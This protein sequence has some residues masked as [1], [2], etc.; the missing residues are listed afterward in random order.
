MRSHIEIR[1]R[2]TRRGPS[3][4]LD[5]VALAALS[6]A[7][8]LWQQPVFKGGVDLIVVDAQVVD[9]RGQPMLDLDDA[10]FEVR[11]NTKR[12]RIISAQLVHQAPSTRT[13]IPAGAGGVA[14]QQVSTV[15]RAF[16]LAVDESSFQPQHALAAMKAARRFVDQIP[17]SDLVAVYK[18]PIGDSSLVFTTDRDVAS[19]QLASVVGGLQL[20][21]TRRN[22]RASEVVDIA[23]GDADVLTAVARREC[24]M[25]PCYREVTNEARELAVAFEMQVAQ[26]VNGLRRL[27]KVLSRYPGRKIL[28][29]VSGGLLSSDRIGGRP[30]VRGL[31]DQ[32][33]AE[34]SL[35]NTVLYVLHVDSSFLDVFSPRGGLAT[36]SIMRDSAVLGS[37]LERFAGKSG[38]ALFRVEADAGDA[39]FDRILRETSAHY[40]LAVESEPGDY[41]GRVHY[42]VVRVGR[43]GAIVRSRATVALP[44]GRSPRK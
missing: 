26:S 7:G 44:A 23:A 15:P 41:D 19:R 5:V 13:T 32:V 25:Q 2:V 29:V 30:D 10:D 6:L 34:A 42:L 1:R 16:V 40:L 33:A 31:I 27:L 28:V 14:D 39:A 35:A 20:P 36:A 24:P 12:R 21:Y 11:I 8:S 9:R 3:R 17:S 4:A 37:G 38:G 22:I 18:Y 43:R